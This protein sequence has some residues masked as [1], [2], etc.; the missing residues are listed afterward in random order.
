MYINCF[1][2]TLRVLAL[3]SSALCLS[4]Q[5]IHFS[6]WQLSPL[7]QNPSNTGVFEGDMRLIFNYRNQWQQVKVPYNSVS[8]GMDMNLQ[9]PLIKKTK[10]A[11][12]IIFNNDVAGDGHYS[13]TD[14]KIP[15]NHKINFKQDSSFC[16]NIAVMAGLS[17]IAI[18][19]N[20]LSYDAQWDGDSYNSSLSN[21]EFFLKQSKL[22]ADVSGG[23]S[24]TKNFGKKINTTIGYALY[25]A[26][27]PN[28]SF[29]NTNGVTLK[30]RHAES[31]TFNYSFNQISS[32]LFEYYGNQQQAF[33]ENMI[34]L[35]Y[36]YTI[37]P[38]THTRINA[39]L[40]SRLGDAIITTVG[41]EHQNIRIQATY[42]YNYSP[43]KR[44][45]NTRGGFEIS[46]IYIHQK[47]KVFIPKTKVCPVFM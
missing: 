40:L 1:K 35:S 16:L 43:F 25:H 36:Y 37:E 6:N 17:N 44:A 41:I 18:N 28:I 30:M 7:N 14:V 15:L 26:N 32:L 11:I 31:F 8:F 19:P 3:I 4:A 33:K 24:L 29:N 27:Q 42:D 9:K 38:K 46:L 13:T 45:T 20:K 10:E 2:R 34:G 47:Q 12:G 23:I 22:I 5:D 39:G 21:G